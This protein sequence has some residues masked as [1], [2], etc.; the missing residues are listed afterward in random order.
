M[1][2]TV[3]VGII[4]EK[5]ERLTDRALIAQPDG[6]YRWYLK[7]HLIPSIEAG[8]TPGA[9]PVLSHQAATEAGVAICKDIHFPTLGRDYAHKGASLMLVPANDFDVEDWLTARMTLIRGVENGSS[10]AR[11]AR[12]G[13]SFL[14]DRYGRVVAERRSDA[15]MGVLLTRA[16]ADLGGGT[17]YA[18]LDD[19]FGWACVAAWPL[20]RF[21]ATAGS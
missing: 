19:M 3:V 8:I 15:T 10:I 13:I 17:Y 4:V 20:C 6:G 21:Y 1:L 14:N 18:L 16:P 5:A 12:H 7:E 9:G 11:S 2:I